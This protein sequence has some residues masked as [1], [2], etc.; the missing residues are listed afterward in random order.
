MKQ[1][2]LF[3]TG[4]GEGGGWVMILTRNRNIQTRGQNSE[5]KSKSICRVFQSVLWLM[6]GGDRMS[7]QMKE[8][9]SLIW[10][11]LH[12]TPAGDCGGPAG[13]AKP[14]EC[15]QEKLRQC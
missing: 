5:P 3:T 14:C 1:V 8:C 15:P 4:W 10:W 13:Q 7:G 11:G 12:A 9:W 2:H 6:V